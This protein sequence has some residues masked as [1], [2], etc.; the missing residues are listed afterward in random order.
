MIC[1]GRMLPHPGNLD[2]VALEIHEM[3]KAI[4]QINESVKRL[5]AGP[6]M[7]QQLPEGHGCDFSPRRLRLA[8]RCARYGRL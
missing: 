7:V 2:S 3:T 1:V 8:E 5:Q 6:R 4:N